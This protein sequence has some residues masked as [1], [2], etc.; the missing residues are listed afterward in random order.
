MLQ[1]DDDQYLTNGCCDAFQR[2]LCINKRRAKPDAY[3]LGATGHWERANAYTHLC[4]FVVMLTYALVRT[5]VGVAPSDRDVQWHIASLYASAFTFASS[6]VY[7]VFGTWPPMMLGVRWLDFTSIYVLIAVDNLAT[8]AVATGPTTRVDARTWADPAIASATLAIF[9]AWHACVAPGT[10]VSFI[11]GPFYGAV[12]TDTHTRMPVEKLAKTRGLTWTSGCDGA[13]APARSAT[14]LVLIL[15]WVLVLPM[16]WHA[17]PDGSAVLWIVVRGTCAVALVLGMLFS[18][19]D[20]IA[21]ALL[22]AT[23][24]RCAWCACAEHCQRCGCFMLAHAWWHVTA[25]VAVACNMAVREHMLAVRL[26]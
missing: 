13:H 15:Q 17:F 7:H 21:L 25:F 8:I 10:I 16:I 3:S 19:H 24:L 18:Q 20:P 9:F 4:A 14:S 12:P 1:L 2:V 26:R 5:Q 11:S 22:K 6:F 23:P